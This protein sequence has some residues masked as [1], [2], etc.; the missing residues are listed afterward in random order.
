MHGQIAALFGQIFLCPLYN[1]EELRYV[2][3]FALIYLYVG[4][5]IHLAVLSPLVSQE[6]TTPLPL[7]YDP[8]QL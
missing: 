7:V 6:N 5:K 1:L 8:F 3:A 2:L 4:D